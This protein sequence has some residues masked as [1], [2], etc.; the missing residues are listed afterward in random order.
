MSQ[1]TALQLI[2]GAA[3][4]NNDG[5]KVNSVLTADLNAY[6]NTSLILPL[7]AT[8]ANSSSLSA[9]TLANLTVLGS[10]SCPA[11]ADST[12]ASLAANVGL[13]F[14]NA[15]LGNSVNGFTGLI[16]QTATYFLGNSDISVFSQ[17][18]SAVQGYIVNTNN[19]ILSTK[20]SNSYYSNTFT[21]MNNLITGS[22]S[23]VN[24]AFS[25]F[26]TD[27]QN[28]GQLIN[29][30]NLDNFGSPLAV[31]QQIAEISEL[32]PSLTV[33]LG[34]VN[35]SPDVISTP[36]TSVQA[37]LQL[38][39]ILYEVMKNI[40]TTDLAQVLDIL[41]VVTP[42][43]TTMADLLNPLLIFPNSFQSLTVKTSEG[44]RG[45]YLPNSRTVNSLLL[46]ELPAYVLA[47]FRE[48][49]IV[50][51]GDQALACQAIRAALQQIKNIS[52]ITL[53]ALSGAFKNC[54]TT[55]DL[56][57]INA[58][59]SPVPQSVLNYYN[60][61]FET[62]SGPDGT[63]V[64]G[65]FLGVSAGFEFD[66]LMANTTEIIVQLTTAGTLTNLVTCYGRMTNTVDGVYGD[67]LL[68]PVTIPPGI[69]AGVY[70]NA[71]VAF[72]TGL[73]PNAATLITAVIAA[74]SSA[75]NNLNNNFS[76][77]A[78]LIIDQNQN[79]VAASVDIAN[80]IPN[81]RSS[82]LGFVSDLPNF[83]PDTTKYGYR[84]FLESVANLSSLGGQAV[85]GC[86]REGKNTIV[87]NT[88]GIAID[89]VIPAVPT[90]AP[91]QANLLPSTYSESQAANLV[92]T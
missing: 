56:P 55:K 83:G 12:P 40:K 79:V 70:A 75:T 41:D 27:L 49:Q 61:T 25:S 20:N 59:T 57:L 37:L 72:D 91:I 32:T 35:L 22:L 30:A 1:L 52:Q 88:Q 69:A 43:I 13:I 42:N 38:E 33:A 71:D 90:V 5:I 74:N 82:T 7:K 11:L 3:L 65:D 2:A 14:G 62:G 16:N 15:A 58:L 92:I 34:L 21:N 39:K 24:L 85:I 66:A 44:L 60:N 29:L 46:T 23:E 76:T 89:T 80:L 63:L 54:E 51:P 45:I 81:Q 86:M 53:P 77:M 26:G 31:F 17:I 6:A 78:N 68:G 48:L 67:P 9:S 36:P 87:L 50:I 10:N 18:F 8:Y 47:K 73:I 84:Q 28:L 4:A 64:I 19:Y